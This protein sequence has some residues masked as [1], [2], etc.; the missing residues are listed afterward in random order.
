ME[1]EEILRANQSLPE[2]S[3]AT[4]KYIHLYAELFAALIL[5]GFTRQEALHLVTEV[6]T[7]H[8]AHSYE[9]KD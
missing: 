2:P 8:I 4:M 6:M 1:F 7:A 9:K 3:A 5:K